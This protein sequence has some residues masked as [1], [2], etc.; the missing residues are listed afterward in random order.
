MVKKAEL[1]EFTELNVDE[2]STEQLFELKRKFDK[3][4][5]E[6]LERVNNVSKP[7][8]PKDEE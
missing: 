4:W 2:M 1:Q 7:A 6:A 3:W 8:K 5:V